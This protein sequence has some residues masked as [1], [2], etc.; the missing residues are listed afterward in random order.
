M[1]TIT[2]PRDATSSGHGPRL[3]G[4]ARTNQAVAVATD[5][6]CQEDQVM[7]KPAYKIHD[8]S[9]DTDNAAK[10]QRSIDFIARS[11]PK[12]TASQ[13]AQ[14]RTVLERWRA[15]LAS[16]PEG[17]LYQR[18][19]RLLEEISTLPPGKRA[20]ESQRLT[21]AEKPETRETVVDIQPTPSVTP[22]ELERGSVPPRKED[23][24]QTEPPPFIE[25]EQRRRGPGRPK[26]SREPIQWQ[27]VEKLWE[28]ANDQQTQVIQQFQALLDNLAGS[29]GQSAE[30]NK[31]LA[32]AIN[33][34]ADRLGV[35]LTI[36][37]QR[38]DVHWYSGA[39]YARGTGATRETQDSS[40]GF[41]RLTAQPKPPKEEVD[42]ASWVARSK[43]RPNT[44]G[45]GG[46]N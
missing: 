6:H 30:E 3:G 10:R 34:L 39:F 37:G 2:E 19:C 4:I 16:E 20:K 22:K 45:V 8:D 27:E 15:T 9:W 23:Q 40:A 32:K 43:G 14:M 17:V 31:A 18:L 28:K 25:R 29:A 13:Q 41:P 7:A 38:V 5:S 1:K 44:G 12:A 24:D 35:D 11:Y 42:I 21:K 33:N 26:Q 46:P 36:D